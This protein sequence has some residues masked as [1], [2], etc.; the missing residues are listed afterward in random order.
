MKRKNHLISVFMAAIILFTCTNVMAFSV[1]AENETEV[2]FND[3]FDKYKLQTDDIF[4]EEK[5]DIENVFLEEMFFSENSEIFN[6]TS[7]HEL[8][9]FDEIMSSNLLILPPILF[10]ETIFGD[11]I[12]TTT[13]TISNR[14]LYMGNITIAANVTVNSSAFVL[15]M[16]EV[17]I[18]NGG[19]LTINGNMGVAG[20][21]RI[22]AKDNNGDFIDTTGRAALNAGAKLTVYGDFYTQSTNTN[23]H[24]GNGIANN[25]SVLELHGN[26]YQL[27]TNTR[28]FHTAGHKT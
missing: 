27:G 25:F 14:T 22:Q 15:I 8:G 10:D 18:A 1:T 17:N 13:K 23:F 11:V 4:N 20:D 2:L 19:I 26:F 5:F 16:G 24:F 21:F 28:F 9:H 12:I 3:F 6:E 7:S